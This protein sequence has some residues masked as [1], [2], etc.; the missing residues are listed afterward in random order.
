MRGTRLWKQRQLDGAERRL[1][2]KAMWSVFDIPEE[3]QQRYRD[4][5]T[6]REAKRE[7]RAAREIR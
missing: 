1:N 2:A 6:E 3:M 5:E 7:A 4:I